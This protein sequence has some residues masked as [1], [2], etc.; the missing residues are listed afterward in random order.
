MAWK[1][2]QTVVLVDED[3]AESVRDGYARMSENDESLG[4]YV[5]VRDLTD[6]E[7][8]QFDEVIADVSDYYAQSDPRPDPITHPA[9]WTE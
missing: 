7:W 1:I 9:Y 2:V 8:E 3:E 4:G 6:A 5:Q